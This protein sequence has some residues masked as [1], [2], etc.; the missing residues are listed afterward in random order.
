MEGAVRIE[1]PNHMRDLGFLFL[2]GS[3]D[4]ELWIIVVLF[5][6]STPARGQAPVDIFASWWGGGGVGWGNNVLFD[7]YSVGSVLALPNIHQHIYH[8]M[9]LDV[10]LH[11][12]TYVMLRCWMFSCTSTHMSCY[13]AGWTLA[14]PHICHATL[15][16]VLLHFHTYVMLR[17]WMFPCTS[18]R[19]SCYAAGWTLALPHICHATL[20]DVP[21][22]FHTYVMLRCWMF[23]CT[24][25][26]MSCYSAG[27]TLALPHIC[28]ATLLDVLLHFHTC[29]RNIPPPSRNLSK[30]IQRFLMVR[31]NPERSAEKIVKVNLMGTQVDTRVPRFG[32]QTQSW[33]KC[34]RENVMFAAVCFLPWLAQLLSWVD[35]SSLKQWAQCRRENVMFAAVCFLPWLA[36]LLSWVDLEQ[37]GAVSQ[38]SKREFDVCCRVL[39][40]VVGSAAQLGWLEQFGAVSQVSKRE[41]DVCCRVLFAVVGSASQLGWFGAV[42][43]SEPSVEGRIWCLLPC[44]FC[45]GWLS[46]S[47]GLIWSSLEQWAK[48]RRE[49]LMFAAVCFLPWLAQLLSWVDWS[50]LEQWAKCRRECDVCCRVLFAVVGSAAQLGWLE[51][52]GA[53]SQVSKRECDV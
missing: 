39:F 35:W 49:N 4:K 28:H 17:C 25:T 2:H 42:S 44:A 5:R 29:V 40:A 51:Q 36:Q 37:F 22:H 1:L 45:R 9:L 19:M 32:G 6:V 23:P 30:E 53:V 14:L 18:T 7:F 11:F 20:L 8:A 26:R 16:D 46:C 48:R 21:L 50:S 10:L 47:V 41:C 3:G 38:V 27:W 15:L 43:S 13:A 52:F 34:R 31:T 12:H 33:A 24:S